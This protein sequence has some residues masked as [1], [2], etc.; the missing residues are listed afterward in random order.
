MSK[1]LIEFLTPE[2]LA[3][4][5]ELRLCGIDLHF[6]V[7]RVLLQ[8]GGEVI[9]VIVPQVEQCLSKRRCAGAREA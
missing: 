3:F 1:Q 2:G 5:V 4:A 8:H 6:C 7:P 9:D